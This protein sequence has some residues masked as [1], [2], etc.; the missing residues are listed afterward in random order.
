M[1]GRCTRKRPACTRSVYAAKAH[2]A[3]R[4]RAKLNPRRRLS[5]VMAKHAKGETWTAAPRQVPKAPPSTAKGEPGHTGQSLSDGGPD[6][7]NS[8]LR[9]QGVQAPCPIQGLRPAPKGCLGRRGGCDL[10][11]VPPMTAQSPLVERQTGPSGPAIFARN[12]CKRSAQRHQARRR[13]GST[14]GPKA[15]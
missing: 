3:R 7:G 2:A 1:T 4:L 9:G 5:E 14:V 13:Q 15:D 10:G 12:H 6:P 8:G 11:N